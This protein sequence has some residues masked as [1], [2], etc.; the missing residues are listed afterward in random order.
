MDEL[1]TLS[2]ERVPPEYLA[3]PLP[4]IQVQYGVRIFTKSSPDEKEISEV[5]IK[6]EDFE[7]R[8]GWMIPVLSMVSLE[9]DYAENPY[10]KKH[11]YEAMKYLIGQ[12][13]HEK[14]YILVYSKRFVEEAG[15]IADGELSTS[16]ALYGIYPYYNSHSIFD[17]K[18]KTLVSKKLLIEKGFNFDFSYGFFKFIVENLLPLENNGYARFMFFYQIY[19]LAMEKIFYM[20]INELK[21]NRSHLGIIREKIKD[22][23]SENKLIAILYAEMGS[24]RNDASLAQVAMSIFSNFKEEAYY[25]TTQKSSMLYDIRNTL[26]H[27]YYRYN[28]EGN[29][30]YLA[31]YIEDEA[32]HI[33]KYIYSV[34]SIRKEME[35]EYFSNIVD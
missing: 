29:I 4:T 15:V 24:D 11:V 1:I 9:H 27:N 16:F 18:H 30:L 31:S 13:F 14:T 19:E 7:K 3:D 20:K 33:L 35:D 23:S 10:F 6:G 26:V 28:I 8:I 34:P 21:S 12:D 25:T 2:A 17:T 5:Y 32:F 22:Y